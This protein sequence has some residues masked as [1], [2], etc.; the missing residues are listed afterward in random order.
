MQAALAR[1]GLETLLRP[2]HDL[3]GVHLERLAD[4]EESRDRTG[5]DALLIAGVRI[6]GH[7]LR[8][9]DINEKGTCPA[10][11]LPPPPQLLADRPADR[12]I[13]VIPAVCRSTGRLEHGL[14]GNIEPVH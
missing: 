9:H 5:P 14:D 1:L 4:L 2:A 3:T 7:R 12:T 11:P 10:Q 8:Q 13:A 6:D